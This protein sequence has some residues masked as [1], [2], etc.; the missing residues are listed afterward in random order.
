MRI[1][2][3]K[4][5]S[6]GDV[7]AAMPAVTD[8]VATGVEVDWLVD[9]AFAHVA[10]LH[11][12]ISRI[13]ALEDR[14]ARGRSRF[15]PRNWAGRRRLKAEM[16]ARQYD[17]V[18][19]LQGLLKSALPARWA[20]APV[21]G[22][23]SASIREPLASRLY[24]IRHAV[25]WT[26]H[27]VERNRALMAASL[28]RTPPQAPGNFGLSASVRMS[29]AGLPEGYG[30]ILHAASWTSKLWPEDRWRALI[31][32]RPDLPLIL[33]WGNDEERKRAIRLTAGFSHAQVLPD[34]LTD[35]PLAD[36]LAGARV[37]VGLDSGL[38]HLANAL[39]SPT[40]WL[41]GST[42]AEKTGPYGAGARVLRSTNP[43]APCLK[44]DCRH[45]GGTCMEGVSA[46]AATAALEDV[47]S[48]R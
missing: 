16:R 48:G 45:E 12:G 35:G 6:F 20:G 5:S 2:I 10:A 32:G 37:V 13:F 9:S 29:P 4:L 15:S 19:D 28:G 24:D 11:P 26:L 1:L 34:R 40:I 31:A 44:R 18:V 30:V 42:S 22:Y 39:G 21:H 17:R 27:A 43:H 23:D 41:F 38:M 8:A 7:I 47:L 3:T 14:R 46:E 33:P 36:F 25:P